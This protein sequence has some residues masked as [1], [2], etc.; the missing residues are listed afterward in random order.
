MYPELDYGVWIVFHGIACGLQTFQK[1]L[2]VEKN[3][4]FWRTEPGEDAIGI[5][6][7][8]HRWHLEGL[9]ASPVPIL[10]RVSIQVQDMAFL[11]ASLQGL[12]RV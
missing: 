6:E 10:E 12:A 3:C 11:P 7:C 8:L 5:R 9:D 2:R 1:E 4:A